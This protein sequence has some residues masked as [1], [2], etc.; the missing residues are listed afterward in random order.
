MDETNVDWA[1]MLHLVHEKRQQ[2]SQSFEDQ[3]QR[4]D[5]ARKAEEELVSSEYY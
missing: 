3:V 1:P 2:S 5:R 4:F